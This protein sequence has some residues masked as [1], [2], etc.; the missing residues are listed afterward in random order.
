M[1]Y[2]PNSY[3]PNGIANIIYF[4]IAD[5]GNSSS[6]SPTRKAPPI[7]PRPH[8]NPSTS[9]SPR[10]RPAIKQYHFTNVSEQV[11]D[12][13]N[14]TKLVGDSKSIGA[15]IEEN[16]SHLPL[17]FSVSESLYG[18]CEDKSLMEG[19]LL[20]IHFFKEM[21]VLEVKEKKSGSKYTLPISSSLLSSILYNPESKPDTAKKGYVFSEI[22]D[23]VNANPLP[24]IVCAL[25]TFTDFK[26]NV[27]KQNDILF[28]QKLTE[29][30]SIPSLFCTNVQTGISLIIGRGC[31][32]KFTTATGKISMR[33]QKLLQFVKLPI[34]VTFNPPSDKSIVLPQ[35]A[36]S[37][38]Y[39]IQEEKV[40][41]SV[42]VSTKYTSE[43]MCT[44][45]T[46]EIFLSV[47]VD[48]QL[49]NLP[50]KELEKLREETKSLHDKFQPSD[51]SKVICDLDSSIN[52]I[53]TAL[54]KAISV[55]GWRDTVKISDPKPPGLQIEEDVEYEDMDAFRNDL[56]N[57]IQHSPTTPTSNHHSASL[58]LSLSTAVSP[59]SL[60]RSPSGKYKLASNR[61]DIS[62]YMVAHR[63]RH[64][65]LRHEV[66]PEYV[67]LSKIQQ[68]ERE[69]E[70]KKSLQLAFLATSTYE[71]V[72]QQ[73]RS[74]Y[75]K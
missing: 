45:E 1:Y 68:Q 23:L 60:N 40:E 15:L 50:P 55:D 69:K 54:Y 8:R 67:T 71:P 32:A 65:A 30:Q 29:Y 19:Q 59:S 56:H 73:G 25:D 2:E 38:V 22:D 28:I 53:Q 62:P 16:S 37:S 44:I 52:Y 7:P 35:S 21:K 13:L 4:A 57:P 14:N 39:T 36:M 58:S 41:K 5:M 31:E 66:P 51:V 12:V 64:N 10:K 3:C 74:T 33:L 17:C 27:V 34:D 26:G 18:I 61:G 46:I 70:L 24:K 49:V 48:V 63:D 47:P 9:N 43:S 75:N 20:S 11:Y 42:I 72:N 6:N